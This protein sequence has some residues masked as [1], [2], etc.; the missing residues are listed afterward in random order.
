MTS[1]AL[2][3]LLKV[4]RH[5]LCECS[6]FSTLLNLVSITH[7]SIF[8]RLV[9]TFIVRFSSQCT[10][11]KKVTPL[12]GR[13]LGFVHLLFNCAAKNFLILRSNYAMEVCL[14]LHESFVSK[15]G[16]KCNC[17]VDFCTTCLLTTC[18]YTYAHC[19]LSF[20]AGCETRPYD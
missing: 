5:K 6:R 4:T 13:L 14:V 2:E 12:W 8:Y 15:M 16:P 3:G 9:P 1:R 7:P 11:S 19:C 17:L 20:K 10:Y 18:A